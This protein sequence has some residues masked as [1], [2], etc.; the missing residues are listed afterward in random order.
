ME[1]T[2]QPKSK[3]EIE[4]EQRKE[5]ARAMR[6]KA[7]AI[8][9]ALDLEPRVYEKGN[10]PEY[11][12]EGRTPIGSGLCINWNV[13]RQNDKLRISGRYPKSPRDCYALPTGGEAPEIGVSDSKSVEQIVKEI[14]RRLLPQYSEVFH[15][16]QEYVAKENWRMHTAHDTMNE[17]AELLNCEVWGDKND[18]NV[19]PEISLYNCGLRGKVST[20]DGETVDMELR[21]LPK[22]V[23]LEIAKLV[24]AAALKEEA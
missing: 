9:A 21:G 18:P 6:E 23:A 22:S 24:K 20:F 1:S 14:K 7:H 13:Y 8:F 12:A 3:W 15:K 16:C 10:E 17:F 4:A 11:Y 5:R 19:R 2:E